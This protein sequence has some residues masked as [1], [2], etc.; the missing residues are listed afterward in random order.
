MTSGNGCGAV[1]RGEPCVRPDGSGYSSSRQDR[2]S[3]EKM[4]ANNRNHIDDERE[5]TRGR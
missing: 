1:S 4:T 3:H 2:R 5:R